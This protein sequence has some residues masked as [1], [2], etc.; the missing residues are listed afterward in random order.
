M[1]GLGLTLKQPK[2]STLIPAHSLSRRII[3]HTPLEAEK[4]TGGNICE[5]AQGQGFGSRAA[6]RSTGKQPKTGGSCITPWMPRRQLGFIS[7]LYVTR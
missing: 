5:D 6:P 3:P 2:H 4:K 1:P 7:F